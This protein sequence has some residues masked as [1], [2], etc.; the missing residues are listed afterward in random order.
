MSHNRNI[1]A[2]LEEMA[3]L[4]ELLGE[5]PFRINSYRKASRVVEDLSRDVADLIEEGTLESLSGIGKTTAE[6]IEQYVR[7]GKI[8]L[9]QE[10]LAKI[11]PGLPGLLE[12]GGLGPKTAARLWKQAGIE[13]LEELRQAVMEEP[14]RLTALQGIGPKKVQALRES[15]EFMDASAGR[16]LLGRAE[17]IAHRIL[18]QLRAQPG[19][20][21]A[22]AAGSLRRGK[23]TIGD[24]DLLCQ[25]DADKGPGILAAFA[26]RQD[27]TKVLS[28]GD[29]KCFVLIEEGLEVDLR[30]V[31]PESFGAAL[32]YFT[33]SKDHNVGLRRM[34]Q[35]QGLK[36]NEYGLFRGEERLA[37]R[38]EADVYE[39]LG[40]AWI[41]PELREDR[42]ELAAA[43]EGALPELVQL[44]DIRGDLHMHTTA[45]DGN[46]SIE[47]MIEACRGRGYSYLCISDHS[48]SQVQANGLSA[49][50]LGRHAREVRKIAQRYED[51]TAWI[52]IEVDIFKD[53]SLDFSQDVL[54]ELDFVTASPHS[55]LTQDRRGAT[56]RI[57]RA[58]ENPCVH[59]IGHP[60]GRLLGRRPGMELDI[61]A[62][63]AA[64]AENCTA[65]EINANDHRLDLRDIHVRAAVEAGARLVINTDAHSIDELDMMRLGILTA[66][67]GWAG[68]GCIVN[69][70]PVEEVRAWTRRKLQ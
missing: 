60:S 29:K 36:L 19:A 48:Q 30:V 26:D 32:A 56:D 15:L 65:L 3:D 16:V 55:A 45:S 18:D 59:C 10:L 54:A 50:R 67:R 69:T 47:E 23:E 13:S 41:P 31:E 58:I 39:A 62:I 43:Q 63:A 37:G 11:P 52:G 49:E 1:V 8:D 61:Q 38:E 34:A 51:F 42:G 64:A 20:Q 27:V 35:E 5:N 9:H 40:L 44:Q 6:R 2:L 68:P 21:R 25:A 17:A 7:T 33:G 14:Q 22:E 66:R 53:G 24:I 28:R 57:I 4:L 70:W 12:V 46:N